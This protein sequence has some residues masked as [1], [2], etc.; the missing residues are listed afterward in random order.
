MKATYYQL[1]AG[2]LYKMGTDGIFRCYVLENEI[3]MIIKEVH[4]GIVGGHYAGRESE[5]NIFFTALW[6][7]TLHKDVKGYFHSYDVF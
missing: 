2:N 3:P 6:W 5:Q 1:I 7:P 4:D